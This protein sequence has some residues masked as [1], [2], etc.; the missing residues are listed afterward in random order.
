[1]DKVS[2]FLMERFKTLFQENQLPLRVFDAL[3]DRGVTHPL[4]LWQRAQA[5]TLFLDSK[6]AEPL[7]VAN[8]RVKNILSKQHIL[9]LDAEALLMIDSR[10]DSGLL[11]EPSEKTLVQSLK[12]VTGIVEPLIEKRDYQAALVELSKLQKPVD[13]FFEAVMVM[14]KDEAIKNNRLHILQALQVVFSCVANVSL[15]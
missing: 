2:T 11:K 9:P 10:I 7:I 5:L 8:K 1:V 13:D 3:A 15:L 6:E 4:D 12:K 14:D